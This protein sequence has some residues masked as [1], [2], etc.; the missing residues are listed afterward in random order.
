MQ[1][2]VFAGIV[3]GLSFQ[4]C[5]P[6]NTIEDNSLKKYFDSAGVTG[7]FALF[8]NA[9]GNFTIYNLKRYRDP[10]QYENC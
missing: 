5:S 10:R 4:A 9:L 6:N 8:D 3:I 7:C 1:K 2:L